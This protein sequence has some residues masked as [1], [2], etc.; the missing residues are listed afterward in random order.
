M[1]LDRAFLAEMVAVEL[2]GAAYHGAPG[3][4]ERD[5]RRDS[6]LARLGWLTVRFS[7]LRL[8]REPGHVIDEL[9]EIL[10]HRRSQLIRTG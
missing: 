3:Q 9:V 2:D 7:H 8:H 4:R 1:I 5:L 10:E 6:A